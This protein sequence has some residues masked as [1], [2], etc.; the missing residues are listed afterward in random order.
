MAFELGTDGPTS[1]L[2]GVD[3]SRTSM[4]AAAYAGG[5]VRRQRARL[6]AAYVVAPSGLASLSP[7]AGALYRASQ[8]ET[9][10]LLEKEL[11]DAAGS[12]GL[13]AEFVHL[14]GD[15]YEQLVTLADERRVDAVVVGASEQAGHRLVGS[16]AARLVRTGRWPVTVVP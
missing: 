8:D 1:V 9:A 7:Q 5:L 13:E 10:E 14:D 11:R 12:V 6:I 2:V 15:V 4:R 3:G 16:L